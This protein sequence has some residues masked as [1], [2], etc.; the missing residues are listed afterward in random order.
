MTGTISGS[1]MA[2]VLTTGTLTIPLMKRT[3]YPAFMA[4]AIEAAAS[5]GGALMPP[6]MG[7]V[8]FIMSEFAGVPYSIIALYAAIPALLYFLGV[9]CTVHWAAVRHGS[10]GLPRDRNCRT[11]APISASAGTC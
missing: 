6:V 9:F 10:A 1:A 3:G 11:G 5:T 8:A 2:N 7:T 4:G